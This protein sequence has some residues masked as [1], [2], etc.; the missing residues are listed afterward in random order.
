[1]EVEEVEL[2]GPHRW[3]LAIV[4]FTIVTVMFKGGFLFFCPQ[5][6]CVACV[7]TREFIRFQVP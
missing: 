3:S 4:G 5:V 7:V 6:V 1:M 2:I